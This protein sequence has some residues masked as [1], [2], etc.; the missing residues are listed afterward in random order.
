MGSE[1]SAKYSPRQGAPVE[2]DAEG[3]GRKAKITRA[4]EFAARSVDI[5]AT[6]P[7]YQ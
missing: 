5:P 2:L 6:K 4:I 7:V 1:V 3:F